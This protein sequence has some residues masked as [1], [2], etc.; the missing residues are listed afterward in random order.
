[1]NGRL[2]EQAY[3]TDF[4]MA[5]IEKKY[6]VFPIIINKGWF[7]FDTNE[8]FELFLKL[9]DEKSLTKLLKI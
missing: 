9:V 3:M 7:E 5:L 1:M 2:F 8:D 4:L 6:K